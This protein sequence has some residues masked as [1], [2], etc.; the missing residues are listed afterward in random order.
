MLNNLRS[1]LSASPRARQYTRDGIT[2]GLTGLAILVVL[3]ALYHYS[4]AR[5]VAGWLVVVAILVMGYLKRGSY[6]PPQRNWWITA[7]YIGVFA[8][9]LVTLGWFGVHKQLPSVQQVQSALPDVPAIPAL[10]YW[11]VK[12]V[13]GLLA[14]VLG[15]MAVRGAIRS[16]MRVWQLG[17]AIA[18]IAL[19]CVAFGF[20]HF[21]TASPSSDVATVGQNP[22]LP[23]FA[24]Y[25]SW[26][27]EKDPSK[28]VTPKL[29]R[30]FL[31]NGSDADKNAVHDRQDQL[32]A[33]F[34][35]RLE[36]GR[37]IA[38]NPTGVTNLK[39]LTTAMP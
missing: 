39:D 10:S 21:G 16:R 13:A 28:P 4:S 23:G 31:R 1:R 22:D 6:V 3:P 11:W 5:L 38:V 35:L 30:E 33:D 29:Y 18:V 34:G 14:V 37:L 7:G 8:M 32:L 25:V 19:F 2:A 20:V 27:N 17:T 36:D 26:Q 9:A 15:I 12:A 24:A